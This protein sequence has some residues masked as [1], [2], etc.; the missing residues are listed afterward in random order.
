[1]AEEHESAVEDWLNDPSAQREVKILAKK[2]PSWRESDRYVFALLIEI[3]TGLDFYGT[4]VTE[5][6]QDDEDPPEPWSIT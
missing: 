6:E 5:A 1:M 3:L 4:V 2:F